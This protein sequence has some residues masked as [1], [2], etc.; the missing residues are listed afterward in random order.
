M[1]VSRFGIFADIAIYGP[2]LLHSL[3][4]AA[5]TTV[6]LL[7]PHLVMQSFVQDPFLTG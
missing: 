1:A 5:T 7:L 3:S 6:L 4:R 2:F